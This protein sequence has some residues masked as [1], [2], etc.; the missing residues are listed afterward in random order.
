[1][2]QVAQNSFK[3]R[4]ATQRIPLRL[5]TQP[6]HP[7]ILDR[8][9]IQQQFQRSLAFTKVQ[10]QQRQV[11]RRDVAVNGHLHQLVQNSARLFLLSGGRIGC[12][13]DGKVELTTAPKAPMLSRLL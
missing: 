7:R 1:M 9:R 2:A 4:L 6:H 11:I 13:H 8:V 5:D 12:A 10:V 3:R